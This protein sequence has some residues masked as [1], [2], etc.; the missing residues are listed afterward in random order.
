[1]TTDVSEFN[2]ADSYTIDVMMGYLHHIPVNASKL[3]LHLGGQYHSCL[4]LV[5][6]SGTNAV[7]FFGLHS[8]DLLGKVSWEISDKHLLQGSLALPVGD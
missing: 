3:K 8:I 1:L 7:T 6:Y 4:D 2:R 5:F